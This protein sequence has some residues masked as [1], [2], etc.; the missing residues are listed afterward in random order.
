MRQA[1]LVR[2]RVIPLLVLGSSLVGCYR[3]HERED[4]APEC[5]P[6]SVASCDAWEADGEAHRLSGPAEP[7]D[8]V[9]LGSAVQIGCTVLVSWT[10]VSSRAG[11]LSVRY[12]TRLLAPSGEPL[13]PIEPHPALSHESS[14]WS[15]LDL[16]AGS[17]RLGGL[18]QSSGRCSFVSLDLEGRELG[19]PV[20]LEPETWCRSIEASGD[21]FSFV[22]STIARSA[23]AALVTVDDGGAVQARAELPVPLD[24]TW[25]SRTVFEDGSFLGYSFSQDLVTIRYTGWLQRYDAAGAALGDEVELGE[26]GVPVHVAET[27]EGA[28]A[29]WT[30]AA[31]GGQPVRLRPIDRD[32][33]ARG[34]TRDVPA[35]GALYGLLARSTPDGGAV[36]AWEEYHF[37]G[38]PEWRLRM[39]SVRPDGTARAAPSTV[40][41]DGHAETWDLL[42]DPSGSRALLLVSYDGNAVD[43]LP[44]RCAR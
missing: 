36:L 41:I 31:S 19:A 16:A 5:L 40:R 7:G 3:S 33:R 9:Q 23:P 42:V 1:R 38:D 29:T 11:A 10:V 21:G 4:T 32:G 44:L 26:N 27:A 37:R 24:R 14:S 22:V 12:E 18:V 17:S 43:A 34:P 30:T 39:Q 8:F 35:E 2:A 13:A 6:A 25:W 15:G 28:L 20:E